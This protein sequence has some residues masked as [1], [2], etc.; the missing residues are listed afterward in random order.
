M[1]TIAT[2]GEPSVLARAHAGDN[3][4]YGKVIQ[5]IKIVAE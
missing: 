1:G 3:V 4:Q 5:D 2:G